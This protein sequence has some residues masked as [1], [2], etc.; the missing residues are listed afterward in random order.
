[1][2]P[3]VNQILHIELESEQ[4]IYKARVADISGNNISVEIPIDVNTGYMKIITT[5]T[6]I[7][8]RYSS[9]DLGQFSFKTK[10]IGMKREQVPLLLIEIPKDFKRVQ[11]RD[12]LRV[13]VSVE[14]SFKLKNDMVDDWLIARTNDI[15]GGG[16]QIILPDIIKLVKGQEIEGWLVLPFNNGNIEH[17]KYEGKVI[18]I[19]PPNEKVNAKWASIAFIDII[20]KKREKIIRFCYEKQMEIG[21]KTKK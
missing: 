13:I 7:N 11:R 18:R 4:A 9:N 17:I 2:L 12:Y 6:I 8:V 20:E 3:S 1:M 19:K 5:G 15:S 14:T 16:I 21:K 10:V